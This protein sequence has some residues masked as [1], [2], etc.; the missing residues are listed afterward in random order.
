L[1][2]LSSLERNYVY[3]PEVKQTIFNLGAVAK[4]NKVLRLTD[5]P[6]LQVKAGKILGSLING[7]STPMH[8]FIRESF[9]KVDTF[10]ILLA[11]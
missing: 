8:P 3:N 1:I 10:F 7:I 11:S 9:L 4:L 6:F 5:H 2:G